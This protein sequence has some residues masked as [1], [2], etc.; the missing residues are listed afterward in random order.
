MSVALQVPV[1][2]P[3]AAVVTQQPASETT[4]VDLTRRLCDARYGFPFARDCCLPRP[5]K[6]PRI[7]PE[8]SFAVPFE[9]DLRNPNIWYLDHNF[10]EG[11]TTINSLE[12]EAEGTDNCSNAVGY[13]GLL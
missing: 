2:R 6:S 3:V 1:T 4:C 8:N 11:E 10:L 5:I 7:G 13:L 12:G 9:E